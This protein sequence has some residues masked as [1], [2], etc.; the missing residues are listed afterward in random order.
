[1]KLERIPWPEAG[2]PDE[3]A[4]RARLAE[5]GFDASVWSDPPGQDYPPHHHDHDESL[6]MVRG[7]MRFG[8]GGR[9]HVLGPGDRLMLPAGTVHAAL[10]GPE[11][12]TYLIGRRRTSVRRR[13][14]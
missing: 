1:M 11:G 6:W 8:I 4:L 2:P 13:D 12:A 7:S 3:S 5:E 9:D 14:Q 10:A